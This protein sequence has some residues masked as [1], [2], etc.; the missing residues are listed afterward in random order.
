MLKPNSLRKAIV[1]ALPDLRDKPDDLRLFVRK[2]RVLSKDGPGLGFEYRYTLLVELLDYA[3]DPDTVFAAILLWARRNQVDLLQGNSDRAGIRFDADQLSATAVDIVAELE[4]SENV[5]TRPRQAGGLE[6][7]HV[8]E[9]APEDIYNPELLADLGRP[10][11]T[12]I[13]AGSVRLVP[14]PDD[15]GA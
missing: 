10:P 12:E 3:G 4:L 11:L 14:G 13:Y 1:A 5:A 8:E 9:P 6:L 15:D 7:V 2:G